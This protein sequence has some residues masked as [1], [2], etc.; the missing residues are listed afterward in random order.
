[1]KRDG[2]RD[3]GYERY[4]EAMVSHLREQV[5]NVSAI[6]ARAYVHMTSFRVPAKPGG[7]FG[8]P[9]PIEHTCGACGGKQ[10]EGGPCINPACV[11]GQVAR[12]LAKETRA[13]RHSRLLFGEGAVGKE[14]NSDSSVSAV[15]PVKEGT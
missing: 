5:D 11:P 9:E 4:L 8:F 14:P 10:R 12:A 3:Y 1:M 15:T 6:A 13:A 2:E 7:G